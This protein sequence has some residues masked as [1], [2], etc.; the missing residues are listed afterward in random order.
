MKLSDVSKVLSFASFRQSLM[1]VP[2][3]GENGL[4]KENRCY[5]FI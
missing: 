5:K 4:L 1:I 3:H 2:T